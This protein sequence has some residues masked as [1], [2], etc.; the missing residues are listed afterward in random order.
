MDCPGQESALLSTDSDFAVL[1]DRTVQVRYHVHWQGGRNIFSMHAQL[2]AGR[3]VLVAVAMAN[4][5]A[6]SEEAV[7]A[8]SCPQLATP[9]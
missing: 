1:N 6:P 3:D 5:I 2:A 8:V 9:R 4:H 7:L